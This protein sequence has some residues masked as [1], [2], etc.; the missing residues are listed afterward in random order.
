[1]FNNNFLP[2]FLNYVSFNFLGSGFGIPNWDFLGTTMVTGTHIR[3]TPNQQGKHGA[4]WNRIVRTI[5][6]LSSFHVEFRI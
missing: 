4:I 2:C 5:L 3:L 1:M 6:E